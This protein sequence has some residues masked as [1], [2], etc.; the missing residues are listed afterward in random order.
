MNVSD[1]SANKLW[2]MIYLYSGFTWKDTEESSFH[3]HN[4]FLFACGPGKLRKRWE[5][6]RRHYT[7]LY[8]G[9][10]DGNLPRLR[11]RRH[12]RLC[13]ACDA[14]N[15]RKRYE[16]WTFLKCWIYKRRQRE[17]GLLSNWKARQWWKS[18]AITAL[19]PH[20]R[21]PFRVL[22]KNIYDN[23]LSYPRSY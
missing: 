9:E 6:R 20:H 15:A 2:I 13:F 7:T 14:G 4:R 21:R 5:S 1:F 8:V 10:H 11:E 23:I 16:V 3:R 18:V 19:G 12:N 22:N 17:G